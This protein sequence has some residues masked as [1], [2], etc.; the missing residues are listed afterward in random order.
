MP[1]QTKHANGV[2]GIGRVIVA[3]RDVARVGAWY[4]AV[5]RQP[6]RRIVNEDLEAEGLRFAV[7][8]HTVDLLAPGDRESALTAWLGRGGS[9][10]YA[11]TLKAGSRPGGLL[12]EAKTM[13]ARL[14]LE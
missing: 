3:V 13:N 2:T 1:R 10:P 8:P 4:E 7:G 5:L 9:S 11:A 6:G 14:S 12:D